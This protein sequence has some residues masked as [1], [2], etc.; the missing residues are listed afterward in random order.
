MI[1]LI[2]ILFSD[3][4]NSFRFDVLFEYVLLEREKKGMKINMF[5]FFFL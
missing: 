4:I 2:I 5:L 3:I 1:E